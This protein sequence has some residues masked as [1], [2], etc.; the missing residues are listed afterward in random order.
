MASVLV[1]GVA[2][3]DFVFEVDEMPQLAEKY[4]AKNAVVVGG[5]CAANAAVAVSRLGGEAFLAARMGDDAMADIILAD[6]HEESINTDAVNQATGGR[7][8]FSSVYVDGNGERQIMNFRGSGVA[9]NTGWLVSAPHTDAILADNRWSQ[10]TEKAM[11]MARARDVPG[12]IDA[13]APIN[14][15]IL[16]GASHVAFSKQGLLALT[17]E[18]SPIS[19]LK[20][21]SSRLASWLCV[22]DGPDGVYFMHNGKVE[23][24]TGFAVEAKDT[25]GAGDIWHG[26][27]TLRLA[28]GANE[29]AAIEFAN[30]AA[31]IKCKTYGGRTGCPDRTETVK[32]LK[33]NK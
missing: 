8:S 7:S 2:V 5:G 9:E 12:V 13:E 24:L 4:R 20:T 17:G 25:L 15:E 31:A 14:S 10:I 23:N 19:A 29:I 30:A 22:T 11:A 3:V 28:E 16:T 21:A 32:F 6:L 1:A 26:A 33:E 18:D 27:F